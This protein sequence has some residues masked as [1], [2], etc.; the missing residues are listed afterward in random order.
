M[1]LNNI[2]RLISIIF[3][4]TDLD[5]FS[6]SGGK[7]TSSSTGGTVGGTANSEQD[8]GDDSIEDNAPLFYCPGRR[9]F[10]SPRQGRATF[11][12]I[13]AFRNTGRYIEKLKV[14]IL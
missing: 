3:L 14:Q 4:C 2:S 11:E 12:R 10:Y 6:L 8:G 1:Y 9:G 7:A 5:V 13:N